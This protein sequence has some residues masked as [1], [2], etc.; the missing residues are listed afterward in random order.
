MMMRAIG[1]ESLHS[2][3]ILA[4]EFQME[5]LKDQKKLPYTLTVGIAYDSMLL[6]CLYKLLI[7]TSSSKKA[8]GIDK[9]L[10]KATQKS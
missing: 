4:Y 2:T 9:E 6:K 10:F 1:M 8:T 5:L 7:L 3:K